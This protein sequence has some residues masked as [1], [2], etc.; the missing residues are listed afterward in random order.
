MKK[1]LFVGINQYKD[2]QIAN[3]NCCIQDASALFGLFRTYGFDA[4]LLIDPGEARVK[5]E[6]SSMADNLKPGDSFFFY[7]AGHGFTRKAHGDQ[8]L[9]FS[10]SLLDDFELDESGVSFNYLNA[11]T[12]KPG[13]SRAFILDDEIHLQGS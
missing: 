6:V 5:N 2:R 11:K 8:V 10:D 12:S 13:V 4:R 3:L 1:A 9:A 7:F